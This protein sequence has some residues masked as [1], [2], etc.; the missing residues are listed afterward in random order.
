MSKIKQ[1][2]EMLLNFQLGTFYITSMIKIEKKLVAAAL[3][4][5]SGV[6]FYYYQDNVEFFQ[7]LLL[8]VRLFSKRAAYFVV[9]LYI[10]QKLIISGNYNILFTKIMYMK[11]IN[12]KKNVIEL[13]YI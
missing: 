6:S 3:K 4:D 1:I 7:Y 8:L 5:K 12:L 9:L 11:I 13:L 10:I 2:N